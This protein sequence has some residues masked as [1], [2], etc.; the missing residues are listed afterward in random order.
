VG[1]SNINNRSSGLDTECDLAIE[2]P[3]NVARQGI[4]RLRERLLA[5][6]L[7]VSPVR[8]AEALAAERSLLRAI[9]KL[10]HNPRGLRPLDAMA[11]DGPTRRIFGTGLLDPRKPFEPL[12]FL[13]R[14]GRRG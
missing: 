13:R 2:A 4:A 11:T 1:S 12:W 8:V 3:D 9:D 5:E 6:H 10:N 14:K 7:G